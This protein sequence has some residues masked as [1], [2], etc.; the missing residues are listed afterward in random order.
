MQISLRA[1]GWSEYRVALCIWDTH[2]CSAVGSDAAKSKN[3]PP[4]AAATRSAFGKYITSSTPS[5]KRLT[6]E[7][8]A[9]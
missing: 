9:A 4:S 3:S 8:R 6:V 7:E 5:A 1:L 2:C